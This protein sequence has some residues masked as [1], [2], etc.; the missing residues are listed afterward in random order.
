MI[1]LKIYTTEVG[2]HNTVQVTFKKI[3]RLS[4]AP[5]IDGLNLK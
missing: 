4:P 2:G 5:I 1:D 3:S